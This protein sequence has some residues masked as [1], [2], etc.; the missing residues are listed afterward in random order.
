M[1]R[2][3]LACPPAVAQHLIQCRTRG[4]ICFGSDGDYAAYAS[5]LQDAAGQ[6]AVALTS[7]YGARDGRHAAGWRPFVLPERVGDVPEVGCGVTRSRT[8]QWE[9]RVVQ[10]G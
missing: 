9:T 2:S 6:E 1:P 3:R 4:R 5:W 7:D 8:R 10:C